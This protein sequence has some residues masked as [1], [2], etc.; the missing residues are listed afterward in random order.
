[1]RL[2]VGSISPAPEGWVSA[3]SLE[4][5]K[6]HLLNTTIDELHIEDYINSDPEGGLR[7]IAW[8]RDQVKYYDYTPPVTITPFSNDNDRLIIMREKTDHIHRLV[9]NR[10]LIS[11]NDPLWVYLD[12]LRVPPR[13]WVLTETPEETIE[14]LQ[15]GKVKKLSLDNDLGLGNDERG[16]ERD[17]YSV[18]RW[19]EEE[20]A[21]NGFKPPS[22]ITVHSGNSVARIRMQTVIDSL[23]QRQLM[24]RRYT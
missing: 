16:R 18:L 6:Q 14:M 3:T 24:N 9:E 4:E 12:D 2:F 5:A 7:L 8:I 11:G 17:G 13:G 19:M 10:I 1:M 23:N 21:V 20:V 15:T 22:E